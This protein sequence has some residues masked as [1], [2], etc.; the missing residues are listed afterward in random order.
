MAGVM[1]FLQA[2]ACLREGKIVG[3]PVLTEHG[4]WEFRMRR[5][6]AHQWF[7]IKVAAAVDGAHV[8][9]LYVILSED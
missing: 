3:K 7:S 1:L 6:A 4:L 9:K 5:Y 8:T 2:I